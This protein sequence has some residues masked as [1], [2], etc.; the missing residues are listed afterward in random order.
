M[1][2][3]FA[4]DGEWRGGMA[5]VEGAQG[6]V[7]RAA[8]A[9][10]GRDGEPAVRSLRDLTFEAIAA[11]EDGDFENAAG[12]LAE[13]REEAQRL[14]DGLSNDDR[15][16]LDVPLAKF[17][18]FADD[19]LARHAV[20]TE[21]RRRENAQRDQIE[22]EAQEQFRRSLRG[23]A[24]P[25]PEPPAAGTTAPSEGRAWQEGDFQ[26]GDTVHFQ[27][28]AGLNVRQKGEFV[29]STGPDTALLRGRNGAER[30]VEY[31]DVVGR[32]RDGEFRQ[33]PPTTPQSS[34]Q[35]QAAPTSE[36]TQ[37]AEWAEGDEVITP[38]RGAGTIQVIADDQAAVLTQSG[39]HMV[40]LSELRRPEQDAPDPEA[41]APEA[42]AAPADGSLDTAESQRRQDES[43]AIMDDLVA[44]EQ[45]QRVM[46]GEQSQKVADLLDAYLQG[47][48][49]PAATLREVADEMEKFAAEV[50]ATESGSGRGRLGAGWARKARDRALQ[51]AA[52]H[53]GDTPAPDAPEAPEASAIPES[54]AGREWNLNDWVVTPNG[55]GR[56]ILADDG[57]VVVLDGGGAPRTYEPWQLSLP[58]EARTPEHDAP[59]AKEA[60]RAEKR[61]RDLEEAQTPEGLKLFYGGR[62]ANLNLEEG[63]GQVL[64]EQGNQVG[65][66]RRRGNVWRGQDARGGFA[67][68]ATAETPSNPLHAPQEAAQ[69]IDNQRGD[70]KMSSVPLKDPTWRHLR[71]EEGRDQVQYSD[72]SEAQREEFFQ[73][74]KEWQ[75]SDDPELREAAQHW[76]GRGLNYQQMNRLADEFGATAD[77]V[78]TAT[79]E[80]RRRQ[81]VLQR[82]ADKVR[83]QARRAW[84]NWQTMPPPDEPDA[85]GN[86]DNP[87]WV[88]YGHRGSAGEPPVRL[89]AAQVRNDLAEL[90]DGA[91]SGGG[92]RWASG[93]AVVTPDGKRGTLAGPPLGATAMVR[94]NDGG[95]ES[96]PLSELTPAD[97]N[98]A[99]PTG[100]PGDVDSRWRALADLAPEGTALIGARGDLRRAADALAAGDEAAASRSLLAAARAS[101]PFKG[102]DDSEWATAA[103]AFST[104]ADRAG[105]E[106]ARLRDGERLST[107]R[108]LKKGDIFRRP[109]VDPEDDRFPYTRAAVDADS[110]ATQFEAWRENDPLVPEDGVG[111]GFGY[112]PADHSI[113]IADK[114]APSVRDFIARR[115][116]SLAAD[117][118]EKESRAADREA[119]RHQRALARN[120]ELLSGSAG[121]AVEPD[122]LDVGDRVTVFQGRNNRGQV[123]TVS[124]QVLA[125]PEEV[126]ATRDGKKVP[127][128]RLYIGEEGAE[129][130]PGTMFT[131]ERGERVARHSKDSATAGLDANAAPDQSSRYG[132]EMVP[133]SEIR[134][135]DWVHAVTADPFYNEPMHLVGRVIHATP[136]SNGYVR[137]EVE[138][139][140]V[141]N[142]GDAIR[143]EMAMLHGADLV[144]RLPEGN[145]GREDTSDLK[146]RIENSDAMRLAAKVPVPEGWRAVDG[147]R[148][149]PRAGD[150][151]RIRLRRGGTQPT[152]MNITVEGPADEEGYWRVK[153]QPLRFRPSS[154][155]AI[156]DGAEVQYEADD[157][158]EGD[159]S[160][161]T[162]NQDDRQENDDRERR[163]RNRPNIGGPNG[164]GAA[165]PGV[166][167]LPRDRRDRDNDDYHNA[168]ARSGTGASR[169]DGTS[170]AGHDQPGA[171]D[172]EAAARHFGSAEKLKELAGQA[173]VV[174]DISGHGPYDEVWLNG[175]R[176]GSVIE[177]G[178]GS[179][180]T[181]FG[182]FVE[183]TDDSPRFQDRDAAV[184]EL[185]RQA[186]EHGDIPADRLLPSMPFI[187]SVPGMP[188]SLP[189]QDFSPEELQR[190]QALRGLLDDLREGRPASGNVAD[191]ISRAIDEIGWVTGRAKL[192]RDVHWKPEQDVAN[193]RRLLD[194]VQPENPRA[195][196]YVASRDRAAWKALTEL[197]SDGAPSTPTPVRQ[198]QA[199]DVVRVNGRRPSW[200]LNPHPYSGYLRSKKKVTR[201]RDGQAE[202]LWELQLG[203]TPWTRDESMRVI[204]QHDITV[205][206]PADA[207]GDLLARADDVD[208]Q[209]EDYAA[210]GVRGGADGASRFADAPDAGAVPEDGGR[211]L[212]SGTDGQ[213]DASASAAGSRYGINSAHLLGERRA[214]VVDGRRIPTP[215]EMGQY[216]GGEDDVIT[217]EGLRAL[218]G[219]P[220]RV[221]ELAA[222]GFVPGPRIRSDEGG[223]VWRNGRLIGKL[224][225]RTHNG[226]QLWEG[227]MP[228]ATYLH[229]PS[230]TTRDQALAYLVLRDLEQGEPDLSIVHPDIAWDFAHTNVGL[231]FPPEE[232][233]LRG[234]ES[235]NDNPADMERYRAIRES[236]DALGRAEMA[237]G[238]VADDLD[239]LHD[240]LRWLD[241]THYKRQPTDL[242][243]RVILGPGWLA[244]QISKYLDVL[245]PEDPRAMH[246]KTRQDRAAQQ[247][248]DKL[249]AE[250]GAS[251]AESVPVTDIRRGDIVHLRG[252]LAGQYSGATD[253]RTGFV[254]GEPTKATFTVAGKR[255]KAVRIVVD[256]SPLGGHAIDRATFLIP[257]GENAERLVRA[258]DVA[259]PLDD[260]TYGRRVGETPDVAANRAPDASPSTNTPAPDAR[261]SA[262]ERQGSA[263]R[264][265][266][267][268]AAGEQ[269]TTPKA[270]APAAD[271]P[272]RTGSEQRQRS[273]SAAPASQ[274][275]TTESA[276]AAPRSETAPERPA[277]PEPIGGRP[278]EWVQISDVGQGDLVRVEGITKTGTPRTLAGYVA[279]GP[280]L[281]PTVRARKVQDM[282]RVLV[283]DEPD[284]SGKRSSVW[285]AQDAAAARATQDGA[286]MFEGAPQTGAA[287]DVLTGRIA[288]QV[289]TDASGNGLFPGSLVTDHGGN[290]GVVVGSTASS[291]QVQ[292]GDSRTDDAHS[293]SSLTVTDGGAARPAGWTAD[294]HRVTDGSL[295]GDREGNLL[296]TV[297]G[298]DGD[299]ATVATP[300]GMTPMSIS[301]LRVIGRTADDGSDGKVSRVETVSAVNPGDVILLSGPNGGPA[302]A[303]RVTDIDRD[304]VGRILLQDVVTGEPDNIPGGGPDDTDGSY[305]RL[306]DRDGNAPDLGPEDAPKTSEPITTREPAPA[307]DPVDGPT[308]D[309][310]LSPEERDTI[311]DRGTAPGDDP[312]AQQAAARIGQDLP[313]TPEQAQALAEGL[314]QGAD[315]STPEGRAAKRAADHLDQAASPSGQADGTTPDSAAAPEDV[316]IGGKRRAPNPLKRN[317]VTIDGI[318]REAWDWAK[319]TWDA[320]KDTPL[321][322]PDWMFEAPLRNKYGLKPDAIRDVLAHLK[323]GTEPAEFSRQ[324]ATPD[325]GVPEGRPEPSTV[326]EV[327][328]GDTVTL[329]DESDPDTMASY[330]VADIA[331]GPAGVRILHLEDGDGNRSPRALPA[332]QSLY[333]LPEADAPAADGDAEPRD[334]NPVFDRDAFMADHADAVARAV[335][336]GAIE[337]TTTPGSIHQLRQQIAQK[338]TPEAMRSAMQKLR[339]DAA[340]ALDAAGITGDERKQM[341]AGLRRE[342]MRSRVAAVRAVVR[343]LDDLE[344]LDGESPE[345]TAKRAADL[346]RLI[347][348]AL[349]NRPAPEPGGGPAAGRV[350]DEVSA[351]VD[352]AI[353]AAL[354]GA[355]TGPLTPQRRAQI[356]QQIAQ[357]MADSRQDTA[358]QIAAHLPA[359]QQPGVIARVLAALTQIARRLV[360]LVAAFLKGIAAAVTGTARAINRFREGIAR[361]IRSWPETRRLRRMAA[362]E[363][364]LTHP[365]D[366]MSLAQKVSHW[367]QLLPAPGRL[368]Q[369]ARRRR[370]YRPASRAALAS[371]QLPQVQDGVRWSMDRAA[372]RGPGRQA[373][374]HLAAVRAAGL[375]VDADLMARLTAAAPEL[376]DDPHG[377]VRH[378]RRYQQRADARV[379]NL[380]AVAAGINAPDLGGEIAAAEVEAQHA[381]QEADR[382]QQAYA[383][384]LPG[385]VRDTLAQVR[386]MG[387]GGRDRLTMSHSSDAAAA[388]AL[389]DVA[390]Y[391]PRDWLADRSSRFLTAVTGD[392]GAYD[393]NSGTATV[394]DLGD[395]GRST[396]AAALLRHL[397]RNYPDL[398]AAQEAFGFTRTHTGRPGARRSALDVLLQRLFG[399]QADQV[400]DDQI[401]A[402]GL[403]TMFSGDW[404]RDDDLRAFLLGLLATR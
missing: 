131:I 242:K 22:R 362:A 101:W 398:L 203:G 104:A 264:D 283:S 230:F 132:G 285:L 201:T 249:L 135:G 161:V 313:V 320:H 357:R 359:G 133:A 94:L 339:Q 87:D 383:A 18:R 45:W 124:G 172:R 97:P 220:E 322:F 323:N 375:D 302:R 39:V 315:T 58:G 46:G 355:D 243:H 62:L 263:S 174:D 309:P 113:V 53:D 160:Q 99:E 1:V 231:G 233:G 171:L 206:V 299:T 68:G 393:P 194:T 178:D 180:W 324:A 151:F 226:R 184:A 181:P 138:S 110:R 43:D 290:E 116:Q 67:T 12:A 123:T 155:V 17:T 187:G 218:F 175:R 93:D 122:A 3:P 228:L 386:E 189:G 66:I 368:G 9:A 256:R 200:D 341:L 71:P 326:G 173:R 262:S 158:D 52:R 207:T 7:S 129:L 49:D 102:G 159:R 356:V 156:P 342:A 183:V 74:V 185:V 15:Q 109:D 2:R 44:A 186:H 281:V 367:V 237:S 81:R 319:S 79:P 24:T 177:A 274:P 103:R 28:R 327:G 31:L 255:H 64:D 248:L 148:I 305:E 321:G 273:E 277:V 95:H 253:N 325:A 85:R 16:H 240:E 350:A 57:Q 78:D 279:D 144:E 21:K 221:Q 328:V 296:G 366:G 343:T 202:K 268:S 13:A 392:A 287:S 146:R 364:S 307:V 84:L 192:G 310:E 125:L 348:E 56:V 82:A 311:A 162:E 48:G 98:S 337:G 361:R 401:V 14:R 336:D 377:T 108:E 29:R 176:I 387:P 5:S 119:E 370:W 373:L 347:P 198:L 59:T 141:L 239:H 40:P 165:G 117:R 376:G 266:Q 70:D 303:Y 227:K 20:T 182:K 112:E 152:H 280:K 293:P 402:R 306:V 258:D 115:E 282:F 380:R 76:G 245:R 312:E 27:N 372:D 269:S 10:W 154:I 385:A 259:L 164:G 241:A 157:R 193:L 77:R 394:A 371:G 41:N 92:H 212:P 232:E 153:N 389:A 222:Q 38:E 91:A 106:L 204:P 272:A 169:S 88:P 257:V 382:L 111:T 381:R 378:A 338:V 278:A 335:V 270:P 211:R 205:H 23:A 140:V 247:F 229:E 388:R 390:G 235:L 246:H 65:W 168:D 300:D 4:T 209:P 25:A 238:N 145:P 267:G 42:P 54:P 89:D 400:T 143:R 35:Q 8:E 30:E 334:A 344:P 292:F 170:P 317:I 363:R 404:Y 136:L 379:R 219:S 11:A 191:D 179:G 47:D 261:S 130:R 291:A 208:L 86:H 332:S 73:L 210:P 50:E 142:G 147:S 365:A 69:A 150:R 399:G 314:R 166:P 167:N 301:G 96:H 19:Y 6:E 61:Q 397:Q 34:D 360:E 224:R 345:D 63:H 37:G 36:P 55:E 188:E 252:R 60:A 137:I 289:G 51:V 134:Q 83:A 217:D 318:S 33:D 196:H 286:D 331:E 139:R 308:V 90:Q 374:R 107:Y 353:G 403:A 195:A 190:Y 271:R 316:V 333:Q 120:E 349:R 163:R 288:D 118:A 121:E 26:P 216:V 126:T 254:L 215:D 128:W 234:L 80:G 199:G 275:T 213:G 127:S 298:V 75:K 244:E 297:E 223:E 214:G 304:G 250:G 100:L 295:V 358:Q 294:G 330:R 354:Q 395:G 369:V 346:L 391:V 236:V 352:D 114:D 276:P 149:R 225:E 251:R 197:D 72:F 105:A 329:P 265:R 340:A 351:H 384:A 32:T 260:H 396:A 284:G